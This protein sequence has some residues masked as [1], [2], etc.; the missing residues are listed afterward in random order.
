METGLAPH[1]GCNWYGC[2]ICNPSLLKVGDTV[3]W[4]N[5]MGF[6]LTGVV[7]ELPLDIGGRP[8]VRESRNGTILHP[9][10]CRVV[11]TGIKEE[12]QD[13]FNTDDEALG[14]AYLGDVVLDPDDPNELLR[15]LRVWAEDFNG[16]F[17]KEIHKDRYDDVEGAAM[18]LFRKLDER[19]RSGGGLPDDWTT[20]AKYSKEHG[21]DLV[22]RN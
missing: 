4:V 18:E 7:I 10:N 3:S 15:K 8:K 22:A 14:T 13:F 20:V 12:S 6:T 11:N 2:K 21:A 1:G 9:R 19:L 5:G 16:S 17:I